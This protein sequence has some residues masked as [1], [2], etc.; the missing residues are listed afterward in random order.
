MPPGGV[1]P[2]WIGRDGRAPLD[3][4][5]K[6]TVTRMPTDKPLA[7]LAITSARKE[8]I[9]SIRNEIGNKWQREGCAI[10]DIWP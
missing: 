4:T 2:G 5:V 9:T 10:D 6:S 8:V 1:V 3:M 7:L